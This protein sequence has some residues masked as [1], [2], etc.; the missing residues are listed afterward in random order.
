[1]LLQKQRCILIS[2]KVGIKVNQ[3]TR[4]PEEHCVII[5]Q[6][7]YQEEIAILNVYASSNKAENYVKQQLI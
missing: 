6:S 7:I 2:D 3:I 4:D 5:K 1:M